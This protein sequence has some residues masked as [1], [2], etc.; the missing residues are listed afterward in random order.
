VIFPLSV[1]GGGGDS[2][3]FAHAA[4]RPHPRHPISANIETFMIIAYVVFII[5]YVRQK[6]ASLLLHFRIP[7]HPA[8]PGRRC[9]DLGFSHSDNTSCDNQAFWRTILPRSTQLT[10]S[11]RSV[12]RSSWTRAHVRATSRLLPM[13]HPHQDGAQTDH[14]SNYEIIAASACSGHTWVSGLTI[15]QRHVATLT[16]L[17]SCR[18]AETPPTQAGGTTTSVLLDERQAHD[19]RF[20]PLFLRIETPLSAGPSLH[21][22]SSAYGQR[23]RRR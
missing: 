16:G 4:A 6:L 9:Q 23:T 14:I 11:S 2:S 20:N 10:F 8:A 19:G 13:I 1:N 12:Q 5:C 15:Q 22:R 7:W 3:D 18:G 21:L 17:Q